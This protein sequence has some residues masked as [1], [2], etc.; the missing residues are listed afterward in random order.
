MSS[1]RRY[2][3][4]IFF[5]HAPHSSKPP[6][7]QLLIFCYNAPTIA[8]ASIS[9]SISGDMNF[10]TSIIDV[11]GSTFPKNSPCARPA[12]SQSA[13]FV[14]NIRVRTTSVIFAPAFASAPSIFF[15][16]CTVCAYKSPAPTIFPS[17]PVAVVPETQIEFPTFTAREYPITGSH[18]VP[19]EKFSRFMAPF[20]LFRSPKKFVSPP[21][22]RPL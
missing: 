1:L 21:A 18:F 11:A 15:S 17:G 4:Q 14:R 2:D 7:P 5:G 16:V 10:D 8:S 9:T 22:P 20:P 6:P 3:L 12:F 19:L 13:M